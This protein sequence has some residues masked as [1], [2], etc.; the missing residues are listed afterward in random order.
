MESVFLYCLIVEGLRDKIWSRTVRITLT[1]K[2]FQDHFL[3]L[4]CSNDVPIIFSNI[5]FF[6]FS[7]SLSSSSNVLFL[8][9]VLIVQYKCMYVK[10]MSY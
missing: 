2:L 6:S 9:K 10:L 8:I 7:L 3:P 5:V 1:D 4:M